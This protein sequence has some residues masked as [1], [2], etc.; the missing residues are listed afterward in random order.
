MASVRGKLL[1][2]DDSVVIH[3][4]VKQIFS[5]TK[6]DVSVTDS[7]VDTKTA[8][9]SD[10]PP[11]VLLLDLRMP[12]IDGLAVGRALKRRVS[13]PIILYSSENIERL[14]AAAADIGAEDFVSKSASDSDLVEAV[15]RQLTSR[16]TAVSS[17]G[18]RVA[19]AI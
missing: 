5:G 16:R 14:R 2:L 13:I 17:A 8:V 1:L 3:S 11:D 7:W 12:T 4:R 19:A 15:V 10:N 9:F 18:F 6:V